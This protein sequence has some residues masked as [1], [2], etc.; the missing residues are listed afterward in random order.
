[1]KL[2][3]KPK[4]EETKSRKLFDD[5]LFL[6]IL[7]FTSLINLANLF[8]AIT[9]IHRTEM[10]VPIRYT[11]IANFDQLG[12]WYQLYYP[13]VIS[14]TVLAINL[15]LALITYKKS[16]LTSIFLLLTALIVAIFAL[17]IT[18]GFTSINYGTN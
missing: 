6:A 9:H 11:S 8:W 1:M 10:P 17:A 2:P 12:K 15:V 3:E 7:I 18:F 16:K 14:L 5:K 13:L 4:S